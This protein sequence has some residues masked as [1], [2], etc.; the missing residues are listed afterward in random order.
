MITFLRSLTPLGRWA[1]GGAIL[2]AILAG[3]LLVQA[4]RG[5][6][7]AKTE[8]R[9][10]RNQAE[11]SIA[12]GTDAVETVGT[13]HRAEVAIDVITRENQRVILQAPGAD[14]PVDPAL[15]GVAR[16]SLCRR[17]AYREHPDCVQQPAAE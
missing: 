3:F 2:A 6:A 1:L 17:A 8:A 15:D 10:S 4:W 16:R 11:A 14:A 13:T 7:T 12:S 5:Q 9:L